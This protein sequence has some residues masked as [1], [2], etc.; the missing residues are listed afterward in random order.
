MRL[1]SGVQIDESDELESPPDWTQVVAGDWLRQSLEKL[2]SPG[3]MDDL[4]PGID[5]QATLRPYQADGVRWL[6]F[7]TRL[8]IGACLA[9]D[10]GL[11]KTIQ[12]ID[13]LLQLKR[14]RD[15]NQSTVSLLI[16]PSSLIGNWKQ[17]LA[18]FAPSLRVFLA[19]RSECEVGELERVAA[20]PQKSLADFDLVITTYGL[21]RRGQWL[22]EVPWRLVILDEAQAIKNGSSNQTRAVKKLRGASRIVLTGT[23]VENHLGDLWSLFDFCSPG[24]LGSATQFRDREP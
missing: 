8:G 17:E 10:M 19:H 23:P 14:A 21:A 5:L 7:M 13:L 20:S 4:Q 24:L 11:G 12:V 1:L 16:V 15:K 6:W 22:S 2:R 9:D 18:K 3:G